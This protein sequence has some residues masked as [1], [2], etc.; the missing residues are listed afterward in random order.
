MYTLQVCLM[1]QSYDNVVSMYDQYMLTKHA[2]RD[3]VHAQTVSCLGQDSPLV[4]CACEDGS[5]CRGH[6]PHSN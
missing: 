6:T 2:R 5:G 4:P 3:V 1:S